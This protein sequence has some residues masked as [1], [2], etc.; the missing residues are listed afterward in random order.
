MPS[1]CHEVEKRVRVVK[2]HLGG[3]SVPI[4]PDLRGLQT[5]LITRFVR[6]SVVAFAGELEKLKPLVLDQVFGNSMFAS[7]NAFFMS[8]SVN[9][10]DAVIRRVVL[11]K[12]DLTST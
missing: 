1:F 12:C 8:L 9:L 5:A 10:T 3:P 11:F 4:I 6:D 7:A 2:R